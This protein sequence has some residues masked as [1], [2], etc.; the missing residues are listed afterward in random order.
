MKETEQVAELCGGRKRFRTEGKRRE[1][2][3]SKGK[4]EEEERES[5]R[6]RDIST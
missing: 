6:K 3:R 2:N 1:R 5:Q 4:C